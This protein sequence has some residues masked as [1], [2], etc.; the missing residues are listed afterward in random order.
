[1][2]VVSTAKMMD[3]NSAL[4]E[5]ANMADIPTKPASGNTTPDSGKKYSKPVPKIAPV[6]PPMVNNGASVPP[7]VPLPSAMAQDKNLKKQSA[8]MNCKD[9]EPERISVMFS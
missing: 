2:P 9:N 8:R 1:C 6:A 5:P 7:E 3:V 4:E